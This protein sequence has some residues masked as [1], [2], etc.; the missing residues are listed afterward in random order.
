M[1]SISGDSATEGL[2]GRVLQDFTAFPVGSRH[3]SNTGSAASPASSSSLDGARMRHGPAYTRDFSPDGAAQAETNPPIGPVGSRAARP[4]MHRFV[5]YPRELPPIDSRARIT[6]R[7]S[8]A[9]LA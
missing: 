3:I 1:D 5:P 2:V 4:R 8:P 6:D 9:P 7:R